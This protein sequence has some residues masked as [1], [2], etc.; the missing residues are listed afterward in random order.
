MFK[1]AISLL[2]S[3]ML[4]VA[5][6]SVTVLS[7]SAADTAYCVVGVEALCGVNW[8][9]SFTNA[10]ENN[11]MTLKDDGTYEKVYT[12]VS[13]QNSLE[14][15]VLSD[16]GEYFGN[17]AGNNIVFNVVTACDVTVKFD[18]ATKKVTV[19]G[20]GVEIPTGLVVENMYAVG[21]GDG[22]WL[23]G[24]SWD[25]AGEDN[26]MTKVSEGVY[27]ITFKDV[28]W[29][30]N[31][32]FKFA[33][34]GTWADQ[35]GA[36]SDGYYIPL[37]Q[38]VDAA[39][40]S[41]TPNIHLN[42][43]GEDGDYFDITLTLDVSAFNYDTKTGAKMRADVVKASGGGEEPTAAPIPTNAQPT[44]AATEATTVVATEATTVAAGNLTV[45]STSNFFP[46][47]TATYDA[48]TKE[49]TVNYYLGSE[50][51][52]LNTQW[53]LK[54][55][56]AV[57]AVSDK[58]TVNTVMPVVGGSGFTLNLG[59]DKIAS[60]GLIKGNVSNLGLFDFS[61]LK[62]FVS[63][64]F[65]VVGAVDAPL[66]TEV[67]LE[68][69]SLTV[70][71]A[72]ADGQSDETQ[73]V[74]LVQN[75][76]VVNNAGVKVWFDDSQQPSTGGE[77][78]PYLTVKATSNYFPEAVAYYNDEIK[79]V[80]VTYYLQSSK[81]V[82]STQWL[83]KYDP[84]VLSLSSKN[85]PLT[86]API[87]GTN[88]SIYN[89]D[90]HPGEVYSNASNL[91]LYDFST[92]Q[93][94]VS[95]VFD[96]KDISAIAPVSTL[97]DLDVQVL[98]VSKVGADLMSDESEEVTLVENSIINT[99]DAAKA[100]NVVTKT[101]IEPESNWNVQTTTTTEEEPT[102]EEQPTAATAATDATSAT[103]SNVNGP[104]TADTPQTPV[105]GN[106]GN[107]AV[108]TGDASMALIILS[109]LVSAT[110]AMFFARKRIK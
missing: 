100:V 48:A 21:A 70:S 57:L 61:T 95:I 23:N 103:G 99:S 19:D 92:L 39:C 33:A 59:V 91:G 86:V 22:S 87:I 105:G 76:V 58:N 14:L 79:E 85:T 102:T 24:V 16:A 40:N 38:D 11:M 8:A 15:K 10:G 42:T 7:V 77:E 3:L 72:R 94:F 50:K 52:L 32:E 68:V 97:V 17:D 47:K 71:K 34:N 80:T 9:D 44:Q 69:E 89:F 13:V 29:N 110:G 98:R 67:N 25:P 5:S 28:E 12:N 74:T 56:P 108:Q 60:Q 101:V 65:D 84:N 18:P 26:I 62:P 90:G 54:Y 36:P 78:S 35:W 2:L 64:V 81:N 45:K 4:I 51:N 66:T 93:P 27:Q 20:S 63:V 106:G 55:D 88:S 43:G 6:L 75:S 107:G 83:L 37:N 104:S 82:L 41:N 109:V 53:T 31:Y 30:D 46:E 73:E 96:V 1:K 49:L